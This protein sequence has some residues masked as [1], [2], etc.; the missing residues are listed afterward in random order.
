MVQWLTHAQM[1]FPHTPGSVC[2]VLISAALNFLK[3]L[4][5]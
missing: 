4:E 2:N 5:K 3:R 1:L